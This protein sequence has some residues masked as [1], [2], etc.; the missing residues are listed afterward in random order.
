MK[1][2]VING[3]MRHGSTWNSMNTLMQEIS[4]RCET[5][6]TEFFLPRDMPHFCAGCFSCLM[7]GEETCPHASSVAPIVKAMLDADL[8]ILTSPVYAMDVSGTLKALLDHLCFM[9]MS[10]RPNP[11]MFNKVGVAITTTA[12]AGLSHTVKTMKNSFTFWGVKKVYTMKNV[13]AASKWEDVRDE[14]KEKIHKEAESMARKIVK[15][16]GHIDRV[17][18][19]LFRTFFLR[20]M[21]GMMKKNTW[22]ATDRRHWEQQGWI[23]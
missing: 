6:V 12:G 5:E 4:K 8:I 16:V 18:S 23:N 10:H 17:R 22:N 13:V 20:M 19:P 15:S 1:I 11:R 9:W 21:R 7:K 3:N 2:T 14:T